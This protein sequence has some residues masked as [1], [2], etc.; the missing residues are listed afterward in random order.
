MTQRPPEAPRDQDESAFTPI[1]RQLWASVPKL[2]AAA[3]V[4]VEGECIDYVSAV[5]P[6]DAKVAAA[7]MRVLVDSLFEVSAK[8]ATGQPILLEISTE[9]RELWGRRI[10]AE[11]LL[12][13]LTRADVDRTRLRS[14]LTT[15]AHG[16]R[17]EAGLAAPSW[18]GTPE[19]KVQLREA[20]GW[21]YA[22]V[23]FEQ[24]SACTRI[25]DVLGRWTERRTAEGGELVC[26]RVRT[27]DGIELTLAHDPTGD[28]WQIRS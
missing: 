18:E 24:G 16:F 28:D 21:P 26:F 7:H 15:A 23:S 1:L 12:V 25:E 17:D 9:D 14:M 3:F 27:D 2:E 11:Y 10:S 4:D 13:V 5:D 20:V 22:P 8:L 6:Y 19:I